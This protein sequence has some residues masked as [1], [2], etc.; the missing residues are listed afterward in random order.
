MSK[1]EMA[2]TDS[3]P[4][5]EAW[6]S[7][8]DNHQFY[9][10]SWPAA[11]PKAAVLFVHGF[12]DHISR[13]DH[14]HSAFAPRGIALFAYDLQGFGRTALDEEHRSPGVAYGE[15]NR[16]LE[17]ADV[18]YW[19]K[20]LARLYAGVPLFLM[21]YSAVRASIARASRGSH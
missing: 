21:T 9:T 13:Y 17:L 16:E 20:H 1:L 14:V 12:A 4:Y 11:N 8:F 18:E 2:N 19:L 15:T 10:R 3:K 6:L 5:T 7:G